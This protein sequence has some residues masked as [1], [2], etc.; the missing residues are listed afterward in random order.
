MANYCYEPSY[1][2]Y[3]DDGDDDDDDDDVDAGEETKVCKKTN[4]QTISK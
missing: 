1:N 2:K 3:D 4:E